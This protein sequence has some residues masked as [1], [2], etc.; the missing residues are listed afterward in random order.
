[1]R[2]PG[3]DDAATSPAFA[4]VAADRATFD[5]SRLVAWRDGAAVASYP[6]NTVAG[7]RFGEVTADGAV[8]TPPATSAATTSAATAP[9][10]AHVP[11]G[12]LPPASGTGWTAGEDEL[13]RT[14]N[15]QHAGLTMMLL[16]TKRPI[17]E[18]TARLAELGIDATRR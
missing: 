4:T 17:D 16:K 12:P 3:V 5:D 1:L 2:T 6:L 10:P 18:V 9:A 14:L 15:D 11:A 8:I 13:L 7:L